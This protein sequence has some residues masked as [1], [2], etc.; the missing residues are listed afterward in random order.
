[1][2]KTQKTILLCIAITAIIAT[3]GYLLRGI[4]HR[5]PEQEKIDSLDFIRERAREQVKISQSKSDSASKVYEQ[6]LKKLN[7]PA[8]SVE[9][10]SVWAK[11]HNALPKDANGKTTP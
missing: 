1:M 2:T 8:D 10:E 5:A 3:G 11:Y 4:L 9:R 6:D 7:L